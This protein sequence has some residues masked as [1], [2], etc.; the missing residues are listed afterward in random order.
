MDKG[1]ARAYDPE[2]NE[3]GSRYDHKPCKL[4]AWAVEYVSYFT[5]NMKDFD[6][7]T[8]KAAII[9]AVSTK[10]VIFERLFGELIKFLKQYSS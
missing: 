8:K 2:E 10:I 9:D 3:Y 6:Y 7:L 5:Q 4:A 1:I